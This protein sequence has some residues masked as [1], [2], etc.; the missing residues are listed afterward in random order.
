MNKTLSTYLDLLRIGAAATVFLGHLSWMAISGGFLWQI[1]TY[2]HSAVIVFF[3]LSGF[4]IQYAADVKERTLYDFSVARLARLYS[5]VAPAILLTLV[6][7]TIGIRH[8]P[9][10]YDLERETY[11]VWR[12]LAGLLFLTQSWSHT[13]LLSN[14]PF[15]SLPYEFWYYV[16]FAALTFLRGRQRIAA[17]I[18][19]CAIAGP[20]ILLMGPIWAAGAL[21]YRLAKHAALDT[22]AAKPLWALT[23]VAAAAVILLREKPYNSI[24]PFLPPAFSGW[25]FVLGGLV[26]ANIFAAF[27]LSLGI[28]RLHAPIAKLAGMTFAL[29]LFHMPL[30]YLIA[31]FIPATL[32]VPVRGLIEGGLVL[33]IVYLLSFVTEGQKRRWRSAIGKLLRPFGAPETKESAA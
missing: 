3:V 26:A 30:L 31:D 23:A 21:A 13:S 17:L 25:D 5:V 2:G 16:I 1:Q 28:S 32:P 19:S 18:A 14:E 11:V 15:W 27:F 12:M 8:N 29:Y 6:C 24:S 4:V 7:D 20:A 9:A 22:R 10:V 33:A